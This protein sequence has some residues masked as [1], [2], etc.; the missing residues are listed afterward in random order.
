LFF[1]WYAGNEKDSEKNILKVL[2]NLSGKS[3]RKASFVTVICLIL[4]G[5]E[6]YFSGKLEGEIIEESRG[7]DGFGYD[8][9]FRPLNSEKTLA[10]MTLIDKNKISHRAI[11]FQ[12]MHN[13]LANKTSF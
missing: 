11:A 7:N 10:E 8:P 1:L 13:F 6:Y 4:E 2:K 12:E 3:N 5:V 9:I